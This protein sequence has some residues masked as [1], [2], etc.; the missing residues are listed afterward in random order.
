MTMLLP[1]NMHCLCIATIEDENCVPIA[2]I[3]FFL[4]P[5]IFIHALGTL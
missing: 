4:Q 1:N 2:L 5:C 3:V